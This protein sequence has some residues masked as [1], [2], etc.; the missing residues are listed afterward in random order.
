MT[1]LV[2]S[3]TGESRYREFEATANYRPF[4]RATANFSYVRS[5]SLTDVNLF[6]P[7]VGTFERLFF[8]TN[9]F[10]RSRS[11]APDR[12][13]AWGEIRP[14]GELVITPALDIHTGYPV[15]FVDADNKVPNEVDFGRLA[16]TISLDLGVHR[17]FAIKAFDRAAR[18]RIG[19]RVYN[20]TDHFN[21]R[22]AELAEDELQKHPVLIRFFNSVGRSYRASLMLDF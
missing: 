22:D 21:P 12:F 10:A 18:L 7:N 11:D 14:P 6:T 17:E 2:L 3:D 1:A 8:S 19:F 20:L 9:R 4:N 5:S 15:A 16:R 13:L